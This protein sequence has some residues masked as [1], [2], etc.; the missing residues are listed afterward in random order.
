MIV[1]DAG[2]ACAKAPG[3]RCGRGHDQARPAQQIGEP[4]TRAQAVLG[5]RH[6]P[7][8]RGRLEQRDHEQLAAG[9]FERKR[10]I[11]GAEPLPALTFRHYGREPLRLDDLTPRVSVDLRR[12]RP[13]GPQSPGSTVIETE[14]GRGFGEQ[15]LLLAQQ[16]IQIKSLSFGV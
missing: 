11:E 15:L 2:R 6:R 5:P 14:P 13:Q 3:R 7:C 16:Q 12:S 8:R 1:V 10:D 4:G 9:L